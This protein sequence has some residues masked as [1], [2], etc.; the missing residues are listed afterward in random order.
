MSVNKTWGD[1]R[2]LLKQKKYLLFTTIGTLI[3]AKLGSLSLLHIPTCNTCTYSILIT[4][5][6]MHCTQYHH[7]CCTL[8][9]CI[10]C[11]CVASFC[12]S[13]MVY[14]SMLVTVCMYMY[15]YVCMML[16][17]SSHVIRS[18]RTAKLLTQASSPILSYPTSIFMEHV[19]YLVNF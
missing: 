1:M 2:L 19:Q 11:S 13:C 15:M 7:T 9:A 5:L 6:E 18:L 14:I 17:Q 12:F 10:S 8:S 16:I 4:D 3:R